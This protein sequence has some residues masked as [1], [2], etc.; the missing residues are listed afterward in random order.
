M[1]NKIDSLRLGVTLGLIV[2]VSMLILSTISNKNYGSIMF[3]IIKEVYPG[4]S[5]E[6]F[7]NKMICG[8]LGFLDGFIGG[9][10]IGIIYNNI[11]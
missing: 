10:L 4:C 1:K 2:G 3:D 5:N 6:T 11:Y 8:L 9:F 7:V